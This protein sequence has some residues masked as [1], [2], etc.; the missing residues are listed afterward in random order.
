MNKPL[1]YKII[2]IPFLISFILAIPLQYVFAHSWEA[3]KSEA[4]LRNPTPLTPTS[5]NKGKAAYLELCL[6]CH[7]ENAE[8]LKSEETGL[9]KITGNLYK[10]LA[11]HSDGD[12]FWKIQNGK[13]EMP[14]FSKALTE[15]KIWDIINYI[16]SIGNINKD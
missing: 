16:K 2:A 3:P 15:D 14:S 12:F 6:P 5:T 13:G 7:G 1:Q 4:Q 8:G 11:T 9:G 10:R